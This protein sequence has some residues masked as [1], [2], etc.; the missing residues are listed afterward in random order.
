VAAVLIPASWLYLRAATEA[1]RFASTSRLDDVQTAVVIHLDACQQWIGR[2]QP[3]LAVVEALAALEIC[4]AAGGRYPTPLLAELARMRTLALDSTSELSITD[5]VDLLDT[6]RIATAG[7]VSA[8]L[9][10]L[11]GGD[12]PGGVTPPQ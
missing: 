6:V 1:L 5:A 12:D 8:Q 7:G 9:D 4:Q 11:G 2:Q 10:R 3:R